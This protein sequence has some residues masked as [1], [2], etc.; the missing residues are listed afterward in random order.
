VPSSGVVT[1]CPDSST[2]L[3][4]DPVTA[5]QINGILADSGI[6]TVPRFGEYAESALVGVSA[7]DDFMTAYDVIGGLVSLYPNQMASSPGKKAWGLDDFTR[8]YFANLSTSRQLQF[9]PYDALTHV[10]AAGAF[11]DDRFREL[12]DFEAKRKGPT[13]R[14]GVYECRKCKST[15]TFTQSKQTRS[16]D[17]PMSEYTVCLNCGATQ[18]EM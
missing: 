13:K 1:F 17:E 8:T 16:A 11:S 3:P 2:R 9:G 15:K 4:D 18:R 10:F 14:E 12:S 6:T 7:S 5:D